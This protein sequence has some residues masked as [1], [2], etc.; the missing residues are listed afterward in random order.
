MHAVLLA[1]ALLLI[2]A[3][4]CWLWP[5]RWCRRCH[6]TGR[7]MSPSGNAFGSCWWCGGAGRKLRLGRR[8]WNLFR[9]GWGD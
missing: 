4:Q 3:V 6:G 2:Y 1:L 8:V 5:F 9:P 7:R